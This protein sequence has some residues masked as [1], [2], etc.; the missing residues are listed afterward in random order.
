MVV[1]DEV[2]T[3]WK[4]VQWPISRYY[5]NISLKELKKTMRNLK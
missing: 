5:P 2:E 3:M 1:K 4:E